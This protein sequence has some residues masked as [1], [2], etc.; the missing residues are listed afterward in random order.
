MRTTV[1]TFPTY[2]SYVTENA[3]DDYVHFIYIYVRY[4]DQSWRSGTRCDYKTDWL[5]VRSPLEELKYLVKK[6]SISSLCCCGSVT[7]HAMPP[8]FSRKWGTE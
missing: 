7:Q 3:N 4:R 1:L 5:W 6:K 8:E 2:K